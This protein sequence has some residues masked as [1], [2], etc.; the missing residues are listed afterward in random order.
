INAAVP[1]SIES[2][3]KNVTSP[4]TITDDFDNEIRQGNIGYTGTGTAPDIGADEFNSGSSK[5]LNLT[6][7]IQGFYDAGTNSMIRDTV[8]IYL[9]NSSSPYAIVDSAKAYISSS[10][11]G[12]FSFQNASNGVNYYL[13]LIHRNSIETW[14]KNPEMFS[15]GTMTYDFS[16][17]ANKA[18]GNN[19]IQIDLSP[20][21]FAIYSGDQN[22]DGNVDLSDIVNVSNEAAYF[23]SGYFPT[24]MNGDNIT[25][26]NDVVITSNNASSFVAK[27]V[28]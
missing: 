28:P 1:T 19:Q 16:N 20:L 26:L 11:T 6:M 10:G 7:L 14:S 5:N 13:N 17:A 12:T 22:Q 25:D 27:I 18:F 15:A 3:G 4:L 23:T 2:G 21:K 9:R 8:R 24:D